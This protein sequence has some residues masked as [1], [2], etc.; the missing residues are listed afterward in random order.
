ME[1][2]IHNSI[3]VEGKVQGVAFRVSALRVASTLG[4][5]GWVRNEVDGSLRIEAEGT[6][7][8]MAQ[9]LSWCNQGPDRAEVSLVTYEPGPIV[10]FDRFEIR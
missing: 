2:I 10:G 9:L 7:E 1:E 8:Q 4:I 6:E 5:G 3:R